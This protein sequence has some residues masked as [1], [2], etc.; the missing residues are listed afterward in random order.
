[1]QLVQ[2]ALE[3]P[4]E[5]REAF[6]RDRCGDDVSMLDDALPMLAV[7]IPAA[8]LEHPD[9]AT[10]S[11]LA[12]RTLD[13]FELIDEIGRG[14]MG[15]VYRAHQKSL[16]RDVAVKVLHTSVVAQSERTLA[17][18]QRESKALARLRHPGLVQ[19]I[20]HGEDDGFY[21]FAMELVVGK[22]LAELF[23][24][25]GRA[26][27]KEEITQ[28]TRWLSQT[29]SALH[30]AHTAG[31][32][33]RDVKPQNVLVDA[34]GAARL[35]DFGIAYDETQRD[36][37][38]TRELMGTPGYMS[39]EQLRAH[40]LAVD[41]RTDV[42]SCGVVLYEALTGKRPYAGTTV[43]ELAE[44]VVST[45]VEPVRRANPTVPRELQWIVE[46]ALEVNPADRYA[47]AAEFADDCERFLAG[48][49]TTAGPHSIARKSKDFATVHRRSLLAFGIVAAAG[50]IGVGLSR[51][52][53]AGD[54]RPMVR[55]AFDR[56]P[57][58]CR[59]IAERMD[60]KTVLPH[61]SGEAIELGRTPLAEFELPVG[62]WRIRLLRGEEIV[63]EVYEALFD[64]QRT[65]QLVALFDRGV[66]GFDDMIRIPANEQ[67]AAFTVDRT[68]VTNASYRKFV[69]NT[70]HR[71]P[72]L[73]PDNW[74]AGLH[75]EWQV[76]PVVEISLHDA[77][78]FAAWSGKRLPTWL[79]W[80]RAARG[81]AQLNFPWGDEFT[82]SDKVADKAN[83]RWPGR[84]EPR[85]EPMNEKLV[86]DIELVRRTYLARTL[87]VD[88]G[89]EGRSSDGL[90]RCLG[91]VREWTATPAGSETRSGWQPAVGMSLAAGASW[92]GDLAELH[93]QA[94]TPNLLLAED[95][96]MR[97]V[98]SCTS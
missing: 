57:D 50:G 87:P 40:R 4:A 19:V 61:A 51:A 32:I 29:A 5:Q 62:M 7:K 64:V 22:S 16:G 94:P 84:P 69:L 54:K 92:L 8:F 28:A 45:P 24:A 56:H 39:P 78:C 34:E 15:V 76:R 44:Q 3:L 31:V 71:A 36:H 42:Y 96:G 67:L 81:M 93:A 49:P 85:Y 12:G 1:M 89:A 10:E 33:H 30:A 74:R 58:G 35:V 59:A 60:V 79:E 43:V 63:C 82:D 27:S 47:S 72:E 73:W 95:L 26:Q 2:E 17:R 41:E 52:L 80:Q 77:Q 86:R 98:R 70:R 25:S 55:V 46:R 88:Q 91:N 66:S 14:G 11:G 48:E 21:Y 37:T 53:S 23:Q 65:H 75:P 20:T 83:V 38:V 97:C 6:V 68:E 90:H 13:D 9:S 18:F